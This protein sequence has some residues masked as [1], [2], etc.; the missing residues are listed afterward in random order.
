MASS[1]I[2]NG[3][4]LSKGASFTH[5][6]SS[7]N[8]RVS[9]STAGAITLNTAASQAASL[10]QNGTERVGVSTTGAITLNTA[11]SQAVALQ[12]GGTERVGV[13]TAGAIT[14]NTAASQVVSLQ[15][16]GTERIGVSTAGA[17]TL[18]TAASQAVALQQGGVQRVGAAVDGAVSLTAA[19]GKDISL[20][21]S[22]GG[23]VQVLGG[24]LNLIVP[25]ISSESLTVNHDGVAETAFTKFTDQAGS[26][27][28]LIEA[29]GNGTTGSNASASF[30]ASKRAGVAGNI[31]RV[32]SA[33]G[34]ALEQLT[35]TWGA[36]AALAVKF[37]ISVT[38]T[39]GVGTT[40]VRITTI[41][42]NV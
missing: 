16:G 23:K 26:A 33:A 4:F 7:A 19:A 21:V 29:T 5:Q 31:S 11:A 9:I 34:T 41:S 35:L 40:A 14:L 38:V 39:Y 6:D 13:S 42:A 10:Q 27:L 24:E 12:Q 22:G 32:T 20:T 1:V 25:Q 28:I 37:D 15:Q 18:N 36:A 3:E 30:V 8:S 17:I 2:F